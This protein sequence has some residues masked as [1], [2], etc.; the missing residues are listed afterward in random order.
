[1]IGDGLRLFHIL[2]K[3]KSILAMSE[4]LSFARK[5]QRKAAMKNGVK[6][7]L[8]TS[9]SETHGTALCVLIDEKHF[10]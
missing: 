3:L 2:I 4:I 1:M 10:T 9:T 5:L 7:F 8:N 6:R